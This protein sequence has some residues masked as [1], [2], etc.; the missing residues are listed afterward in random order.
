MK[1]V[2]ISLPMNG[3]TTAEFVDALSKA[4]S[5]AKAKA[6][7]EAEICDSYCEDF[8]ADA[9]VHIAKNMALM[10]G[11][12]AAYFADGWKK[13]PACKAEHTFA[14]NMGIKIVRD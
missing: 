5:D 4:R 8:E 10:A 11:A 14:E 6:G 2:F 7:G 13:C 12:D 1:K 3:M 9:K